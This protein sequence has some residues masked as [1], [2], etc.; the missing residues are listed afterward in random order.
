MELA[1]SASLALALT[2]SVAFT[3]EAQ[4]KPMARFA[5]AGSNVV[6]VTAYEYAFDMPTSIPA[7]LTTFRL[8]DKG[9]EPHH[10]FVMKLEQGKKA[11]DLLAAFKAGT[12]GPP[13]SWMQFVGGPN[14]PVAGGETNATLVLEP[15]EY[16]AFCVIPTPQG[17]PHIMMGM[18]KGF[19]V[20]PAENRYAAP[21]PKA[22]LTITLT[23]YDFVMSR[24]LTSGRQVIAVTNAAT[25]PHE[26]V[27]NRFSP[28]ETNMQFA[29]WGENPNGKPAPGHLMGGVTDIPPGKTVV[30]EQTF[31]PGR[32]GFICFTRDKKDGKPHFLHGMQKEF[33]VK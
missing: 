28:G 33:I 22:D 30:I 12:G 32:Y 31:P 25:Q 4:T 6:T 3:V 14:A 19:T 16:A 24:P 21:L 20:T 27:I 8:I 1:R 10:L 2:I 17:A 18:I 13:P 29:A 7:G 5:P 9:K 11:S 26:M 23:D 15:G